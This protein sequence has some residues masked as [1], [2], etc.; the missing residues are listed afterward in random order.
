MDYV[1]GGKLG[2]IVF[3]LPTYFHGGFRSYYLL[4]SCCDQ[5]WGI[6]FDV[7]VPLLLSQGVNVGIIR[8]GG[9]V[10]APNDWVRGYAFGGDRTPGRRCRVGR[11]WNLAERHLAAAGL[12]VGLA[13]E[14]WLTVLPRHVADVVF[15]RSPRYR[16]KVSHVDW[17][18]L[19]RWAWGRSVF[20]GL[21]VEWLDFCR[22]FGVDV[23]F[24]ECRDYLEAASIIRGSQLLISNQ[25]GLHAV[26][27]GLHH[28][29]LIER[30]EMIDVCI[31]GRPLEFV[32]TEQLRLAC[33]GGF[34]WPFDDE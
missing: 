29:L 17:A 4:D 6:N 11:N 10:A 28:P 7:I 5:P 18:R 21:R 25:T 23:P 19:A 24:F 14:P 34:L 13:A 30:C 1:H 2:D 8:G 15:V 22:E 16:P 9:V 27:A 32:T 3:S 20:L 12:D 33:A 26:A 31:F